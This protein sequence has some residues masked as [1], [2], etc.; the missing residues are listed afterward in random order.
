MFRHQRGSENI[1]PGLL[2]FQKA[3]E[4]LEPGF[5]ERVLAPEFGPQFGQVSVGHVLDFESL[6]VPEPAVIV[7]ASAVQARAQSPNW[8]AK[9]S[10]P[11]P[12]APCQHSSQSPAVAQEVA[13]VYWCY[14]H[15][16]LRPRLTHHHYTSHHCPHHPYPRTRSR[17]FQDFEM[18]SNSRRDSRLGTLQK[19]ESTGPALT[20]WVADGP[21]LRAAQVTMDPETHLVWDSEQGFRP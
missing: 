19:E 13:A 14:P 21:N 10:P 20:A 12:L 16:H 1:I 18:S 3:V 11:Q 5:V 8:V 2:I 6:Q 15:P 7:V 4:T 17:P 9:G